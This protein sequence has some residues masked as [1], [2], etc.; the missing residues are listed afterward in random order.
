MKTIRFELNGAPV[1]FYGL[2]WDYG[3]TVQDW[4]GGRL[5]N[6]V[7]DTLFHR[8]A[9]AAGKTAGDRALPSGDTTF[10]SDDPGWPN[11]GRDLVV[12]ELGISWPHEG[13]D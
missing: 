7:G 6:A 2:A 4:H 11:V 9:L 5:A 1:S 3:G 10:R 12:A 8:V 13:E